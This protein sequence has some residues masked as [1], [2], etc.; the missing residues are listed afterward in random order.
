MDATFKCCKKKECTSVCCTQCLSIFHQSCI[1]R[2]KLMQHIGGHKIICSK[3]C[4]MKKKKDKDD[5]ID[6][7][8]K[9]E[10]LMKKIKAL[11]KQLDEMER[12]HDKQ[13]NELFEE[14]TLLKKDNKE[15]EDFIL[16]LRR[17]SR[18]FA[19][20]V[21]VIEQNY[22]IKL[23][24][25]DGLISELKSKIEILSQ[26]NTSLHE[27]LESTTTDFC[28]YQ[29]DIEKVNAN[30]DNKLAHEKQKYELKL[31][32]QRDK[33][34]ELNNELTEKTKS[35]E[36]LEITL[37][38]NSEYSKKL[39]TEIK[40]LETISRQMV[41]SIRT[42][43][44]EVKS[45]NIKLNEL[46]EEL[47]LWKS[48]K[49]IMNQNILTNGNS[50]TGQISIKEESRILLVAGN[51]GKHLAQMIHRQIS[52]KCL[53]YSILKPNATE[54]ELLK[55][56]QQNGADFTKNDLVILWPNKINISLKKNLISALKYTNIIIMTEPYRYDKEYL[57]QSIYNRNITLIKYLHY[58]GLT[59]TNLLKCNTILR[60]SNY[61]HNG[62]TINKTGK[63]Y[64]SKAIVN[65]LYELEII[66]ISNLKNRNSTKE[67]FEN[68][69]LNNLSLDKGV[70]QVHQQREDDSIASEQ[71]DDYLVHNNPASTSFLGHNLTNH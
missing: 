33:M 12:E 47:V 19:D 44:D 3:E 1:M 60:K 22:V 67:N 57:N 52:G 55:T 43:E 8:N 54:V 42:L 15:R 4:A 70:I 37:Q 20:E 32:H 17:T 68:K 34:T 50:D 62:Y 46:T 23:D 24:K 65:K 25:Q 16:K 49:T 56:I 71:Q 40:E 11:E 66:R 51:H 28:K 30:K 2:N 63:W 48:D 39:E 69:V 53:I 36:K 27:K 6:A 41:V 31:E 58:S 10:E 45:S 13:V 64:L 14:I 7:E 61:S 38:K 59:S 5:Q 35:H 18:D 29:S 21:D 26:K 9:I